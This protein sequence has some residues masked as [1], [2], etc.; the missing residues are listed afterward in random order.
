[1]G[2]RTRSQWRPVAEAKIVSGRSSS[3]CSRRCVG[4]ARSRR[5]AVST[6]SQRRCCV[7]SVTSCS[8][9]APERFAGKEQRSAPAELRKLIALLTRSLGRKIYE[10][11]IA[12]TCRGTG[13]RHACRGWSR[14]LVAEGYALDRRARRTDHPS[15]D[16]RSPQAPHSR[17][18]Q[19]LGRCQS[20]L[21][22][23]R[24]LNCQHSQGAGHDSKPP[25]PRKPAGVCAHLR[26]V[27]SESETLW[28]VA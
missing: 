24:G 26:V 15:S 6:R 27:A 25:T 21:T 28:N 19:N 20:T 18:P 22:K 12:G 5:S 23:A 4:T 17:G 7:A 14:E 2:V 1:L 9:P 3:L 13:S 10:L 16:L 11:E 8:M